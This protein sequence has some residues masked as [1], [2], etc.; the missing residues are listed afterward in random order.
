MVPESEY[1]S[2]IEGHW[3]G[4]LGNISSEALRLTWKQ[5]CIVLN[6]K[7][8]SWDDPKEK[9]RWPVL[10]PSTGTGKT[11]GL[12]VYSA[13]LSTLSPESHPGVLIVCRRKVDADGIAQQVNV[14][15]RSYNST[16]PQRPPTAISYHSGNN[17]KAS[18]ET[19]SEF[20]VLVVCHRAYEIAL[21]HSGLESSSL[22]KWPHYFRFR[23]GQRKLTVIDEALD[24]T[25]EYRLCLDDVRQLEG[26]IPQ[27]VMDMFPPELCAI[28]TMREILQKMQELAEGKSTAESILLSRNVYREV[29]GDQPGYDFWGLRKALRANRFDKD[30]GTRNTVIDDVLWRRAEKTL[31]SIEAIFKSWVYY[32]KDRGVHT[33]NTSKLL[34]PENARGAVI[35]DATAS[36]NTIYD[37]FKDAE[38]IQPPPGARN[39]SNVTLHVSDG[40]RVGKSFM[41]ENQVEL[42]DKL[43]SELDGTLTGN[44]AF[45][46]THKDLAS[47]LV[48][49]NPGNFKHMVGHWGALDGSNDWKDCDTAVIFGLPYRPDSFPANV[50][51]AFEGVQDNDW[52]RSAEKREYGKHSDVRQAIANNQIITDVVQAINRIRCR[53]VIDDKGNCPKTDIYLL[54]PS[55]EIAHEIIEGIKMQMSDIQVEN[56]SYSGQLR[57]VRRGRYQDSVLCELQGLLPDSIVP[58]ME[59]RA[60][61]GIPRTPFNALMKKIRDRDPEDPFYVAIQEAG[62]EYMVVRDGR[63]NVASLLKTT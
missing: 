61:L 29:F 10:Q 38:I 24:L 11:Q 21:E 5:I 1:L 28:A 39:Y 16:L 19:L 58:A 34:L 4:K 17:E 7:I 48:Q 51:M 15:S 26:L 9:S 54:L 56:W 20:P 37:L 52:L 36:C 3:T 40:H 23:D 50:F 42:C 46:V 30:F 25:D 13:L 62:V 57:R 45:I 59:I 31:L 6:A 55:G 18:L 60:K 8:A 63:R 14:L 12:I 53:K 43:M 44:M 49:Y 2:A 27:A 33:L 47:R 22:G 41:E 35:M 32:V